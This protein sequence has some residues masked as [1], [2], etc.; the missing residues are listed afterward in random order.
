ML[1]AVRLTAAWQRNLFHS[2]R[3]LNG[4]ANSATTC[5]WQAASAQQRRAQQSPDAR[6]S[7]QSVPRKYRGREKDGNRKAMAVRVRKQARLSEPADGRVKSEIHQHSA[8][9]PVAQWIEHQTTD[10]GVGGSSPSGRTT[11][12]I[13]DW[14]VDGHGSGGDRRSTSGVSERTASGGR[15]GPGASAIFQ[16]G[17]GALRWDFETRQS[18]CADAADSWRAR[19]RATSR[20]A[21][22]C[23]GAVAVRAHT[24][25]YQCSRGRLSQQQCPSDLGLVGP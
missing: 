13:G 17:Q 18:V 3:C 6:S 2:K 16:W 25:R 23:A 11:K 9:A 5:R 14:S 15:V 7:S 4:T 8:Y 10:L 12:S 21:D 20:A 19:R 1:A 22:R 24:P